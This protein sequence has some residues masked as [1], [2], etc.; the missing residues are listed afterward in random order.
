MNYKHA[1]TSLLFQ[2]VSE[3]A[4]QLGVDC[5]V[6]GGFVRDFILER[7]REKDIDIVAVGSGIELAKRVAKNLPNT[8]KIQ[9]FKTYGTAMIRHEGVELE[10]VES[11]KRILQRKQQKSHCGGRHFRR[12]S[13]PKRFHDQ[14]DGD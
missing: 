14:C 4:D 2:V 7:G 5:Y 8:P 10:F 12:R 9:I 11:T 3:S 13:K 6:V 1:L